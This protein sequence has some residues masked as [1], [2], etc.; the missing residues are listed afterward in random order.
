M[1][2]YEDPEIPV[3]P[4][5]ALQA[6]KFDPDAD[7][8]DSGKLQQLLAPDKSITTRLL[9][10]A[11]SAYYG[12]SGRISSLKDAIT[13][14]GLKASKN[15]VILLITKNLN[16]AL[17][18]ELYMKYVHEYP[19]VSALIGLDLVLQLDKKEI[20][21]DIFVSGLLHKIGMTIIGMKKKEHYSLMLDQAEINGFDIQELEKEAY[22]INHNK[23]G[24]TAFKNWKLPDQLISVVTNIDFEPEDVGLQT[25]LTR[26]TVLAGILSSK[27]LSID[28]LQKPL[29]REKQIL[30][31]YARSFELTNAFDPDYLE[32]LKEHPFYQQAVSI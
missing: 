21:G 11:N 27:L 10:V 15:L 16:G 7:E 22:K 4:T 17:K 2:T 8:S 29:E 14:L 6:M 19:V 3:L 30:E 12:R 28:M 24:V 26:L 32:L 23:V 25:D 1:S 13:L 18:G 5:V 20:L 9:K 31:Y